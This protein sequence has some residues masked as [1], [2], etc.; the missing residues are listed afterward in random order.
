MV[1]ERKKGDRV[2]L[3]PGNGEGIGSLGKGEEKD[4]VFVNSST[5]KAQ[6]STIA[7]L[8]MVH[9][10]ADF[11]TG[12]INPLIPVFVDHFSLTLT[13]V[14]WIAGV[15]RFLAFV[16]QP[17]IGY[18]ADRYRTRFFILGGPLI[19]IVF[20]SLLGWAPNFPALLCFVALGSVG[21]SMFHPTIAGMISTYA[22][23][24]VG[25]S[26]SVFNMG[27]T[28]AFG[29]GPLFIS[30]YVSRYG[31]SQMHW[32][33]GIGL[34]VM[35]FLALHLPF[36]KC[37]G[38][39]KMGLMG[40]LREVFGDVWKSILIIWIIMTLRA[41]VSQSLLTY[42]PVYYAQKGYSLLSIGMVVS[43]FTIS[44]AVSGLLAGKLS[45]R[46][47][48]RPIFWVTHVATPGCILMMLYLPAQWLY[49]TTCMTG[50][51]ALA[52]LPVGLALAQELAPKGKSMASSLMMGLALGTGGILTPITGKLADMF[53]IL[54]VM[55]W[56]ALAP[57]AAL[58]LVM[59][60]PKR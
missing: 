48:Y 50:F 18:L 21:S 54:T 34:P 58:A 28:L 49:V 44:G 57:L 13:Q 8:T 35:A 15:N 27:G 38:L 1:S 25:F 53:G 26:M 23:R 9:F 2:D 10:I 5:E 30:W 12:F 41:F 47:G 16:V 40:A 11:Y 43:F 19:V 45:D 56:V 52:I 36:P 7:A 39:S 51:F 31:I 24:H 33:M 37:E 60:L 14:G 59:L 42:L 29:V 22:G 6:V 55:N 20:T 32:V 17:P 4:G 46:F 3:D